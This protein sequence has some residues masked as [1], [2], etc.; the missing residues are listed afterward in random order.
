VG[1]NLK[2]EKC[3][4]ETLSKLADPGALL[5][6]SKRN[7]SSNVMTIGWGLVGVFWAKPVFLAA[8][9]HSRFTHEFIEDN[10]EFTVNV[11]GEGLTEAVSYCGEVS[12]RKHGKFKECKLTV[13][14]GKNV[15]VP[16]IKECKI[17]YEC[18][19][20]HKLELKSGLVPAD[21]EKTYYSRRAEN[22]YHTLYF[23]E[24]VAVY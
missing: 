13:V 9:K 17:H 11:P 22:D 15:M 24:I 2:L 21:V 6:G 18:K 10:G 7:G 8:V 14:K 19:V 5:V 16:V 1:V 20:V 4:A 23:G 3:V 12:G